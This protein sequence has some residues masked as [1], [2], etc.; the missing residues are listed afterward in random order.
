MGDP[1]SRTDQTAMAITIPDHVVFRTFAAETVVLN[2][3]TGQYHGLNPTAG[4]MLET[5]QK[6]GEME[7][8][9]QELAE[10]FS[11]P[12]ERIEHDLQTLCESLRA[13]GL[14]EISDNQEH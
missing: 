11:Q 6:A 7:S 3:Q 12:A 4:R 14:I 2:V 9:V 1:L 5:L 8:A 13:R 10:E